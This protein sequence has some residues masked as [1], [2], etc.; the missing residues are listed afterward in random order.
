MLSLA[1]ALGSMLA[2]ERWAPKLGTTSSDNFV[3]RPDGVLVCSRLAIA[4]GAWWLAGIS[5]VPGYLLAA[6]VA[7]LAAASGIDVCRAVDRNLSANRYTLPSLRRLQ[8]NAQHGVT[9]A[10][11]AWGL[12]AVVAVT[13]VARQTNLIGPGE[14][15][16]VLLAAAIALVMDDRLHRSASG[17][18]RFRD[19][20]GGL[21]TT[22]LAAL[23]AACLIASLP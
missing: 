4:V 20:L 7:G 9:A 19:R 15:A 10:G 1:T 23:I 22:G 17:G 16:L 13:G 12:L 2:A 11:A 5:S 6:G 3:R 18:S 8:P 21:L 14:A